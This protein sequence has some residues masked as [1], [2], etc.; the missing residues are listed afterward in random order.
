[1]A[2]IIKLLNKNNTHVLVILMFMTI[3]K[4]T[5]SRCYVQSFIESWT[6]IFAL[7]ICV[8]RKLNFIWNMEVFKNTTFNDIS[9]IGIPSLWMNIMSCRGFDSNKNP[10]VILSFR[11]KVV[12]ITYQNN[13]WLFITIKIPLKTCLC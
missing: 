11:R 10:N 1:M 3:E 12:T 2:P 13:L 8:Y 9:G 4:W 7:I 5:D 6:T